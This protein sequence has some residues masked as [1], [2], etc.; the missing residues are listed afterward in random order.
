MST[1][2]FGAALEALKSGKRVAR[3]GWNGKGLWLLLVQP[4]PEDQQPP[5]TGYWVD[6]AGVVPAEPDGV[7]HLLQWIGMKTPNDGFVPWVASQTDLLA[8]DWEVV[9]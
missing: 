7:P 2:S 8:E 6:W 3:A 5:W 1:Y 4:Q 9:S